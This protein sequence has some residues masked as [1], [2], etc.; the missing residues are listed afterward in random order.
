MAT[1][2]RWDGD[3]S[4]LDGWEERYARWRE[5][6]GRCS[7]EREQRDLLF[8]ALKDEQTR[9][10]H[11]KNCQ[12]FTCGELY[13]DITGR[14]I[15]NVHEPGAHH[16]RRHIPGEPLFAVTRA[17]FMSK[18]SE[19]GA[20]VMD[21]MTNRQATHALVV[22]LQQHCAE[23]PEDVCAHQ[24]YEKIRDQQSENAMEYHYLE[25]YVLVMRMLLQGEYAKTSER[26]LL[27]AHG[28]GKQVRAVQ[29]CPDFGPWS[30]SR[31][32]GSNSGLPGSY[33]R[34]DSQARRSSSPSAH[35][36]HQRRSGS[37]GRRDHNQQCS[38][39]GG[40]RDRDQYDPPSTTSGGTRMQGQPRSDSQ[41]SYRQQAEDTRRLVSSSGRCQTCCKSGHLAPDCHMST[42]A[43]CG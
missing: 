17:D 37:G 6:Y 32:S 41:Y 8:C 29:S 25:V 40:R 28:I 39:S 11:A 14:K 18:W 15:R 26:F 7:H 38:G 27:E 2:P 19:E 34:S 12:R 21:G 31:R 3:P 1:V 22:L 36:G 23:C 33:G 5:G 24:P 9:G 20:K 10:Q 42:C 43:I 35:E 13:Q 4:T 30:N 16:K